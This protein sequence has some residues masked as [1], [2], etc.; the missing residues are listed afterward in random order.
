MLIIWTILPRHAATFIIRSKNIYNLYRHCNTLGIVHHS[1]GACHWRCSVCSD[2]LFWMHKI[3]DKYHTHEYCNGPFFSMVFARRVASL[4]PHRRI[5]PI[6]F[7]GGCFSSCIQTGYLK[8]N[9]YMYLLTNPDKMHRLCIC[10]FV[11][12]AFTTRTRIPFA[13]VM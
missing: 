8:K 10:V 6:V 13:V 2:V 1:I 12:H 3:I 9:I 11:A 7:G 4:T 5:A